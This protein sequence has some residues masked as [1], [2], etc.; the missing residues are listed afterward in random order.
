MYMPFMYSPEL[1]EGKHH[2]RPDRV[3]STR[4]VLGG[5]GEVLGRT[6]GEGEKRAS[7]IVARQGCLLVGTSVNITSSLTYLT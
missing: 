4:R 2:H 5:E 7:N 6:D 3:V 1:M